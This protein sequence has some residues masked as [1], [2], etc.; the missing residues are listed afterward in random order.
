MKVPHADFVKLSGEIGKCFPWISI[1]HRMTGIV[2]RDAIANTVATPYLNY[3]FCDFKRQTGTVLKAT[4]VL[5]SSRVR[6]APQELVK[7]V[8]VSAM[9][10]Y[11]IETRRFGVFCCLPELSD[12]VRYF[13]GLK[14]PGYWYWLFSTWRVDS[15]FDW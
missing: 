1:R 2:R 8:A 4:A 5:I 13:V 3:S 11:A 9:N 12:D 7:E 6:S 15:T 10:F 14:S